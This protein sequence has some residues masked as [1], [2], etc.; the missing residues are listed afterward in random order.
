MDPILR[1]LL[2][3]R[4]ET[5]ELDAEAKSVIE[6][7]ADAAAPPPTTNASPPV[8]LRSVTVE[9]FRGIGPP[10]TLA[11]EPAPGLTVVVGRNGSGKSSFAEGLELLMTGAL[12]RW[13]KRPKAW[14]ETWQCLHHDG[15]TRLSAELVVEGS[16]ETVALSQKWPHGAG[17]DDGAGRA[18]PATVLAAHGWDRELPSFRPFLAYAELAT[19]FDTLSSLYD[20]LT[21]VLGLGDVDELAKRLGETRLAYDTRRKSVASAREALVAGLDPEDE[22]AALVAGVLGKR[23]PDLDAL[24]ELLRDA[25]EYGGDAA[26]LRRLAGLTLPS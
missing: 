11:L 13:E 22:R 14:S 18:A 12:K 6:L 26:P 1:T 15:A 3:E 16:G 20:A 8:W 19:M 25:P 23:A 7:A 4:L 9:G 2:L 10:A 21:P 5:S 17:Y 24:A